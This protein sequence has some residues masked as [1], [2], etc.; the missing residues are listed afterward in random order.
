MFERHQW[1]RLNRS[2][3]QRSVVI[4]VGR[5][6]A[7]VSNL[8]VTGECQEA[9]KNVRITRCHRHP[10]GL[11]RQLA[12]FD[13]L[14]Q[15]CDPVCLNELLAVF[16]QILLNHIP[17]GVPQLLN[18]RFLGVIQQLSIPDII[19]RRRALMVILESLK[20][21]EEQQT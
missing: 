21:L 2:P 4:G 19:Q 16:F 11:L 7:F 10:L 1:L 8:R 3:T 15:E 9:A 13:R 12:G 18:E 14:L 20:R 6:I 5:F 17:L